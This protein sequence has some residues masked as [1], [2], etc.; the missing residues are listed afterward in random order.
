MGI[1]LAQQQIYGIQAV[2]SV[3]GIVNVSLAAKCSMPLMMYFDTDACGIGLEISTLPRNNL[4]LKVF[5]SW[6]YLYEFV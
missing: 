3:R 2:S 5:I 6:H 1:V 4:C